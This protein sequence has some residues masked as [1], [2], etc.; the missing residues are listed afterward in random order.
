MRVSKKWRSA[1][2]WNS[3]SYTWNY[4]RCGFSDRL[5]VKVEIAPE[6]LDARVP[7][8]ILQPLVENAIRH[9]VALRAA[10]GIVGVSAN[11]NDNLLEIKVY[12]DGPGLRQIWRARAEGNGI[13]LSN[14]VARLE[15]LYGNDYKFDIHNRQEGGVEALLMLPFRV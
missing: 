1:R 13:G 4:N 10:G 15:Q 12:D 7:N 2:N 3:W 14:T 5:H 8:L 11:R 6:T 9:G